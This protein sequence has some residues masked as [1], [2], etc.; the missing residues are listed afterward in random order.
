MSDVLRPA[1]ND[2]PNVDPDFF[3]GKGM[4]KRNGVGRGRKK[5]QT[6]PRFL[7]DF[8]D[9]TDVRF[10]RGVKTEKPPKPT[11][12]GTSSDFVEMILRG[13]NAKK[14]M[15][16]C[17]MRLVVCIAKKYKGVGVK[18]EDLVQEGSLGL[19]RAVERF[20]PS[21]GFK[22]S[23]YASWWV[24]QAVFR[25]MA[26][27]SRIVRLPMHIHAFL[28][29][30]RRIRRALTQELDRKPTSIELAA[31]MDISLEKYERIM[32]LTKKTISLELPKYSGNP[33]D[34]GESSELRIVDTIES[35]AVFSDTSSPERAAHDVLFKDDLQ[36]ILQVLEEDERK[37]VDLRY[38]LV[39]G[40]TRTAP[41]VSQ[42][43]KKP[44][45]WVRSREFRALRKLRRPWYAKTLRDHQMYLKK[46]KR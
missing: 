14:R 20:D 40:C 18:P 12:R 37:V 33:K 15:I 4:A 29:K 42:I 36:E 19:S 25:S 39:D 1:S 22:F 16:H 6:Y 43:M 3:V 5:N 31:A 32:R 2:P 9:D 8:F 27:H 30:L 13:R 46:S 23:T 17:N 41:E 26:Y 28:N 35:S 24:Q 11:N 45:N 21:R 7:E 38:G 34:D 10:S 44:L